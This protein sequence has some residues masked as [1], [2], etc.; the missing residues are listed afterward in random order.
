MTNDADSS[1]GGA[2]VATLAT[3]LLGKVFGITGGASGI[4]LATAKLLAQRGATP[5]IA[6]INDK[7]MAET[8]AYFEGQNV[9]F[10]MTKVDVSQRDQ[11][12]AWVESIVK[13]HGRLDGAANVAGIIGKGHG[14]TAVADLEDSEWHKI[15]AVNLTG[16]MYC[17]RAQLRNIVD[18]GSIVNVSSVHGSKGMPK[19]YDL[20]LACPLGLGWS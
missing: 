12:D 19:P 17:M 6:D 5:C 11:V 8:K 7:A 15:I 4:G 2:A 13:E 10:M 16:T 3:P 14:I 20:R 18:G 1:A 9:P